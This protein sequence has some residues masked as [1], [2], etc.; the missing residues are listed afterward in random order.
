MLVGPQSD[1]W[2]K[3]YVL[4]FDISKNFRP[5]TNIIKIWTELGKLVNKITSWTLK[6]KLYL[7]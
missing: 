1:M 6:E 4:N 3:V 2:I 5:E 7:Y